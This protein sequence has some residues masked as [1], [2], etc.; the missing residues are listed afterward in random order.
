[1]PIHHLHEESSNYIRYCIQAPAHHSSFITN[2]PQLT[3]LLHRPLTY[4]ITC[5][6]STHPLPC[7]VVAALTPGLPSA[8]FALP[9]SLCLS[10]LSTYHSHS[11]PTSPN[12]LCPSPSPTSPPTV[13]YSP[14]HTAHSPTSATPT[15]SIP[16]T[17]HHYLL[18]AHI[19]IPKQFDLPHLLA[20]C[21]SPFLKPIRPLNLNLNLSLSSSLHQ[22]N[23]SLY[24]KSNFSYIMVSSNFCSSN[25]CLPNFCLSLFPLPL[26]LCPPPIIK[27]YPH[28]YT[29]IILLKF[30]KMNTSYIMVKFLN[31]QPSLIN[32]PGL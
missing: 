11:Y 8:L 7:R 18:S 5:A 31:Y 20:L 13:T 32:C 10:S 25:F 16:Y 15:S 1:L 23:S 21:P 22:Y 14:P 6:L 12:T 2:S 4:S 3:L 9:W 26:A 30:K 24:S 28:F 19:D 29:I 27:S 17:P